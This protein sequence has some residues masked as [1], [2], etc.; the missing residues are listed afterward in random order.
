VN[1]IDKIAQQ[2]FFWAIFILKRSFFQKTLDKQK[3]FE[4]NNTIEPK[5]MIQKSS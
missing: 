1:D 5:P 3:D 4:Y 2:I